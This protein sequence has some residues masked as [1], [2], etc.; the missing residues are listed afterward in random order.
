MTHCH[1]ARIILMLSAAKHLAAH[2]ARPF[3]EFTLSATNGLRVTIGDSSGGASIVMLSAAKHLAAH[4]DRP[5]Q[6]R[7]ISAHMPSRPRPCGI[8]GWDLG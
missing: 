6:L 8:L 2:P 7:A 5:I 3:A 4:P 1:T